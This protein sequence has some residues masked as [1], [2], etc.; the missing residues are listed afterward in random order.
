MATHTQMSEDELVRQL[1]QAIRAC[2]EAGGKEI[3]DLGADTTPLEDLEEFDSL[4]AIEVLVDLEERLHKELEQDLFVK[5]A[6]AKPRTI[7]EVAQAILAEGKTK[8]KGG[9]EQN[10]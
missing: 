7:R 8:K 1:I 10:A 2:M 9:S 4:C 5:G 6:K 3:P